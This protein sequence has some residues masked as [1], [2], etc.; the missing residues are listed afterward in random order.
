MAA[1]NGLGAAMFSEEELREVRDARLGEGFVEVMCGCT[2][3]RYGDAIGRLRIYPSGDLEISCECT[4]GCGEGSCPILRPR[5]LFLF[6]FF[7]ISCPC[8]DAPMVFGLLVTAQ[9]D[10]H[11]MPVHARRRCSCAAPPDF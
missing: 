7:L 8:I 4:Q 1:A 5:R 9:V 6:F 11:A 10:L 2:S 3:R